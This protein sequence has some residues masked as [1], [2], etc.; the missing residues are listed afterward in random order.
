MGFAL[1]PM[2]IESRRRGPAVVG[3]VEMG[4][5]GAMNTAVAGLQAQSYAL[6]NVSGNIANSQTRG[7]KRVDTT[8]ADLIPDQPA[9]HEIAGTVASHSQLTNTIQGGLQTTGVATNMAINGEG[10]FVVAR[11][12]GSNNGQPTFGENVYTRRGDFALDKNGY[13]VNGAGYT[14]E[15]FAVDPTTGKPSGSAPKPVQVSDKPLPAVA[16]TSITYAAN[17][18]T[19]PATANASASNPG[20]ELL[21]PPPTGGSPAY[22]AGYDPRVTSSS[23]GSGSV[24]GQD[25]A[26]FVSQSLSGGS[27]TGYNQG[28]K[29]VDVQ[30]R[31]AKVANADASA[32]PPVEDTWNL[33]Y[34]QDPAATGNAPAWK[35]VGVPITFNSA[36]A[37]TSPASGSISVP[38]LTVSGTNLGT[39][40]VDFGT[41]GVTQ[42]GSSNGLLTN[43]KVGQNGYGSGSLNS[44]AI[45]NDGTINGTYSNGRIAPLGQ[46]AIAQF[47]ADDALKRMDGGVYGQTIESGSPTMGLNGANLAGGSV[48]NSNVDIADEFSKLIVTQQAYSANTKV[49]TTS[50]QMLTDVI[51]IIR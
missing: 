22:P 6:E 16:T 46:V 40:T 42:F 32:A 25:Q 17:L 48:E 15:G 4:I 37:M 34:L 27:V 7:Y 3:A 21:G 12:T 14:L 2:V 10:Y 30:L 41:G 39:V 38:N 24:V 26:R 29:A 31:W 43:E 49:L 1:D 47:Q 19:T 8:F 35:N 9:H 20:S 18:P 33:F 13:L 11:D 23:S 28:G 45:A 36:G 50:Q 44:V 51:N 5:F